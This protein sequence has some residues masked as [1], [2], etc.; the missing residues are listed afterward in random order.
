MP[1]NAEIAKLFYDIAEALAF[2]GD[3]WRPIAYRKA[4]ASL[5]NVEDV[6]D[7]YKRGGLK[8]LEKIPGIGAAL[9]SKIEEYIKTGKIASHS[10]HVKKL[11]KGLAA[12]AKIQSLGPKKAMKLNEELGIETLE[13]LEEAAKSGAIRKLVSFGEKSEREILE[14]IELYRARGDKRLPLEEVLP[15]VEQ[16]K[17]KMKSLSYVSK[18]EVAGSVRRKK[19]TIGDID[20]LAISRKPKIVMNKFCS[21]P[22]VKKILAKGNTK[23]MVLLK[24]NLQA[25][26]RVVAPKSFGGA[27]QYFTGDKEHNIALRRIAIKKGYKLSEYGLFDRKTGEQV[28]GKTEKSIYKK[29]GVKFVKP[30][31]RVGAGSVRLL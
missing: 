31:E 3:Q 28:A 11:P 30:E 25:D 27:L 15:I 19:P 1:Y 6:R 20:I 9:A 21:M 26:I 24:N 7:L 18:F 5:N 29:L 8:E 10:K 17:K 23:S 22:E 12:I 14:G 4:A 2:Q 16:I 13:Q